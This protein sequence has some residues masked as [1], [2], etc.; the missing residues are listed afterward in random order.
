MSNVSKRI[1]ETIANSEFPRNIKDLLKTLLLIELRN[2]EDKS[3]R[4]G[5]DYDRAIK[6]SSG[7]P[8]QQDDE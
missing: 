8:E 3:P 2:F 7:V 4:Y 6:E 5:E 1:L